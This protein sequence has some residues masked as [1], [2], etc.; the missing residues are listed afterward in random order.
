MKTFPLISI[1][2]PCYNVE[3][4]LADCVESV[5]NQTYS[6]WELILV[7]DGSKDSTPVLCDT[8][9]EYDD[10]IKVIHKVNGGLVSARNAGYDVVTGNWMTYL[11]SDD[12]VSLDMIEKLTHVLQKYHNLDLIFWCMVQELGNKT[13]EGKWNWSQYTSGKVYNKQ[14]NIRLSSYVLNYNSGLSDAV[15]K[16]Y[17]TEWCKKNGIFHNPLLKQGEESVD[18][19]MRAFY[20]ADNSFFLNEPFY[21]YR[22]IATSISKKVDEANAVCISDCMKVMNNFICSIPNN[23]VFQKEFSFRNAYALIS[24]AMHTYFNPKFNL[25]YKERVARFEKIILDNILFA[26]S[27]HDVNGDEFDILRR[28]AFWCIKKKKYRLLSLIGRI[29]EFAVECGYFGY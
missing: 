23:T 21:H 12:W 11:D 2:V 13:I 8:Y 3:R 4:Y 15:C 25:S 22:Y 5:I 28:M 27:L 6:N 14:Q 7:D 24:I 20:Y 19:V 10:R 17:R 1:I 9:A 29:K 18:F 26:R 16:L